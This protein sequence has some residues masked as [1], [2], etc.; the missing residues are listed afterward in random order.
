ML[1]NSETIRWVRQNKEII[2]YN[3]LELPPYVIHSEL[4][5]SDCRTEPY[6]R[7]LLAC[8]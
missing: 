6:D 4:F 2:A 3:G 8:L 7:P 1:N 5:I